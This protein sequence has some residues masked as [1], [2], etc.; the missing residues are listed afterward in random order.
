LKSFK[1]KTFS[2]PIF[3]PLGMRTRYSNINKSSV[4]IIINA[5]YVIEKDFIKNG[6]KKTLKALLW[7]IAPLI[8]NKILKEDPYQSLLNQ[9]KLLEESVENS[10]KNSFFSKPK[11]DKSLKMIHSY[12][13][14]AKLKENEV[15]IIHA[16]E[17][18]HALGYGIEYN[19]TL[20]EFFN[21]VIERIIYLKMK[22][23]VMVGISHFWDNM[24]LPQT[25]GT[26]IIGKKSGKDTIEKR[27]DA[28]FQMK[29]ADWT[30]G[31]KNKL[32]K[33]FIELLLQ[34]DIIVDVVHTQEEARK[35]VYKICKEY[36]K[37]VVAS[38]VGLKHFFNHEYNLSDE[39][40]LEI[41]KLKGII[42]LIFSKRWLVAPQNRKK[43][44]GGIEDLIENIKYI[45]K[46]TGDISIVGIGTDFDGFTTPFTDLYTYTQTKKLLKRLEEEFTK[47]EIEDILYNNALRVLK[48]GWS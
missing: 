26:E 28:M 35:E 13:E 34:N 12:S 29:R 7:G 38:H 21:K 23:L 48:R 22:G 6:F 9:F 11:E 2:G 5:H 42:G 16:I 41:H 37:P 8:I 3:N 17:G 30:F 44:K 36:K 40:L 32:S 1:I 31:D 19:E 18:A 10:N 20:D 24:Y 14:I 43:N 39:E 4:K 33:E 15:G 25:D 47:N 45:K 27:N 46:L